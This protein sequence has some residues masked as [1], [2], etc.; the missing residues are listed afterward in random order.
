MSDTITLTI[1]RAD[2][3]AIFAEM[4]K[5]PTAWSWEAIQGANAI[6][7]VLAS[8]EPPAEPV[9]ALT[10]TTGRTL[11]AM[12]AQIEARGW[13][14]KIELDGAAV[15]AMVSLPR[16]VLAEERAISPQAALGAALR[17]ALRA[18]SEHDEFTANSQ[19]TRL[20]EG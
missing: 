15:A 5:D 13:E 17:S 1:S 11:E 8:P 10:V 9:E 20:T 4:H 16:V 2:A 12:I 18:A 7:A 6:F 3:A 14:W 19:E